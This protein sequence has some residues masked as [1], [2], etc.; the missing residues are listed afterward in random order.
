MHRPIVLSSFGLWVCA[1]ANA[2]AASGFK[3]YRL[4][5]KRDPIVSS[6]SH[7][8]PTLFLSAKFLA[9]NAVIR[10]ILQH[11]TLT[12]YAKNAQSLDWGRRQIFTFK[13]RIASVNTQTSMHKVYAKFSFLTRSN[14]LPS[15]P[16]DVN[17][18]PLLQR[19]LLQTYL[20]YND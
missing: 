18:C 20:H 3:K 19:S 16:D 8:Y 13:I 2:V 6:V 5:C 7:L 17:K 11:R 12:A 15:V 10:E 1:Q 14:L 9:Q 4:H